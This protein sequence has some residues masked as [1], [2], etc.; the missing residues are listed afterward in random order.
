[1]G[2]DGGDQGFPGNDAG[3]DEVMEFRDGCGGE[4]VREEELE[5]D[6]GEYVNG[7]PVDTVL[8]R[9]ILRDFA[10]V[11]GAGNDLQLRLDQF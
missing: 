9:E 7:D 1:M 6:L 10:E 11:F 5:E 3:V 8:A 2:C 4:K